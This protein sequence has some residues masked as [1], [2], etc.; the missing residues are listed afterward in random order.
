VRTDAVSGQ[1]D[2]LGQ[3]A[4]AGD[5][6]AMWEYAAALLRLP[7]ARRRARSGGYRAGTRP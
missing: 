5:A 6:E 1:A 7:M 2:A 3:A 4:E